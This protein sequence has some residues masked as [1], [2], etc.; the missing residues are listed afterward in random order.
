LADRGFG[1]R[2]ASHHRTINGTASADIP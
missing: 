2:G 1:A